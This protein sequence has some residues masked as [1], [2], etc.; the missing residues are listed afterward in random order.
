M[1]NEV[2]TIPEINNVVNVPYGAQDQH[3]AY[4]I[5]TLTGEGNLCLMNKATSEWVHNHSRRM[6]E[7]TNISFIVD[8]RIAN[9][10]V[11]CN[12]QVFGIVNKAIQDIASRM[13]FGTRYMYRVGR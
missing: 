9:D 10:V 5:H 12:K 2:F 7:R 8:E 3:I 11:A 6:F 1:N 4:S 13:E